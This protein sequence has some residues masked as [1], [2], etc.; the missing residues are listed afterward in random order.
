VLIWLFRSVFAWIIVRPL[1]EWGKRNNTTVDETLFDIII[2]P[3]RY[4]VLAFGI[5]VAA[6]V[7]NL[8]PGADLFV[9]RLT[10]TIVL[11]AVFIALYRVI[12]VFAFSRNRL[13][14]MTGMTIEDQL[15][16]FVR[17]GLHLILI[18][19][20]IVIVIQVWGY[21]VSALV[22]G[23]GL[24][25]LA[26]SLA[27][28]DT[29]SNIFGFSTIVG[30]RPFV[31]GEFIKTPDVEGVVERVGLRSTRVRQLNQALV[32][33]PN[34]KLAGS[35]ILNWSRLAKRWIDFRLQIEYNATAD[36]IETL[37][38]RIRQML[39]DHE[40]VDDQTIVVHFIEFSESALEILIRAYV[41]RSDW[42][43]FTKVRER[44]N[45]E[46][47][48]IVADMGLKF[49]YPTRSLVIEQ[50]PDALAQRFNIENHDRQSQGED[51]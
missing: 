7:L 1:R 39:R 9:N 13:F 31:V 18:A 37:M 14:T 45:L 23:L 47:M 19:F 50:L 36:Q 5:T 33:I 21:D 41:L 29:I 3:V 32:T 34:S 16:P 48:R 38:E 22:A 40:A 51:N 44:V 25:G 43:E 15:L 10:R 12:A 24:G 8:E 17:T 27:A 28:Q 46:V 6:R 4:L 20:M 11:L 30:D 42:L 26:F 35:A 49:A 2:G